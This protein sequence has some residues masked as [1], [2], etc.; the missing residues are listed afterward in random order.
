M[1]PTQQERSEL[2]NK[3]APGRLK[4]LRAAMADIRKRGLDPYSENFVIDIDSGRFENS[5][6]WKQGLS[7]TLTRS[8]GGSGGPWLSKRARRTSL[9][10]LARFQGLNL[11]AWKLDGISDCQVGKMPLV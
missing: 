5:K 11:E 1:S 9:Q 8:R 4:A 6:T 10:E 2:E 3:L 7:K